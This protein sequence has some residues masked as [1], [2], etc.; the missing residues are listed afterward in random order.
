M[1][2]IVTRGVYNQGKERTISYLSTR[3]GATLSHRN[4]DDGWKED[5]GRERRVDGDGRMRRS[6]KI[7]NETI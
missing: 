2:A 6:T 5:S 4:G 3:N 1:A 7:E